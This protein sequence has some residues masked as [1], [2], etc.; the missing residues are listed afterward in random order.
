MKKITIC[1]V[2][3]LF[4]LAGFSQTV[5]I[6]GKLAA[7]SDSSIVLQN[8]GQFKQELKADK[9]GSF[10]TSLKVDR[11]YYF[12]GKLAILYLSP[13]MSINI[14]RSGADTVITGKGSIENNALIS[15]KKTEREYFPMQGRFIA[16]KFNDMEP[17][18]F[19]KHL[20]NYKTEASKVLEQQGMDEQF[21][22]DQKDNIQYTAK[23]YLNSYR[24]RYGIDPIKELEYYKEFQKMAASN[25]VSSD[26]ATKLLPYM[27]AMHVKRLSMEDRRK[28]DAFIWQ[29]FDINKGELFTFSPNYRTLVTQRLDV[30][31]RAEQSKSPYLANTPA[32]K[33]EFK[34]DVA[35]KEIKNEFIKEFFLFGSARIAIPGSE[36]IEKTYSKYNSLAKDLY[37]LDQIKTLYTNKKLTSTGAVSPQFSFVDIDNKPVS[38][39]S[40]K[41]N[42]VYIDVW[43]TWCVPCIKEIPALKLLEEKY[44]SKPIKFVSISVD[45]LK[46]KEKWEA[47]VTSNKLKGIQLFADKDFQSDFIKAY[48]INAIPRFILI[49]PEGKIVSPNAQRPSNPRI[50]ETLNELLGKI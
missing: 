45:K 13:G 8:A 28:I 18:E 36:D 44:H 14:Q 3:S 17:A 40:L 50:E 38:L 2:L 26:L 37:Y 41:G 21:K 11:G 34:M 19:L 31:V 42:Y 48:G 27:Q 9:T 15:L 22:S 30:L 29:D 43:A 16:S 25:T 4:C 1:L 33:E 24:S 46:D 6:K 49:N 35:D 5:T 39:S 7:M 12:L 20:E 47:Y 32:S 10:S 23:H